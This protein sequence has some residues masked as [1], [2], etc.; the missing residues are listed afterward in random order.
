MYYTRI[1]THTYTYTKRSIKCLLIKS[2]M[3]FI[4]RARILHTF[5]GLLHKFNDSFG[6]FDKMYVIS[7][8]QRLEMLYAN[9]LY[10]YENVINRRKDR[11][12]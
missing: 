3:G 6:R 9:N 7:E 2:L 12:C 10:E 4:L 5:L 1:Q 11:I 8:K